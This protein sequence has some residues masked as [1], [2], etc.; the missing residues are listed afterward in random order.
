M[1][2][3]FVFSGVLSD[4]TDGMAVVIASDL[5]EAQRLCFDEFIGKNLSDENVSA[6]LESGS[7]EN[8][9]SASS[10]FNVSADEVS[11]VVEYVYGGA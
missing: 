2:K 1:K 3:L 6:W 9:N 8:F 5:S 10:V 7:G 4:Y 11:R